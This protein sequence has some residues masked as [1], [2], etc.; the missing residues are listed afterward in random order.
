MNKGIP[1]LFCAIFSLLLFFLAP[2]QPDGW[3]QII[4]VALFLS[5]S[6]FIVRSDVRKYGILNFN[7]L[8]LFSF[9]LVSYA[10][11]LFL[12]GTTISNREGI[13]AYIDFDVSCKCSALC[14]FAISVYFF[15]YK[16][17][18]KTNLDFS[19]LVKTISGGALYVIYYVIVFFLYNSSITHLQDDGGV[20]VHSGIWYSL[21]LACLPLCLVKNCQK[22]HVD[23]LF[24]YF[25]KNIFILVPASLL[26][27]LYFIIGDRGLIIVSGIII[28]AVYSIMV[29]HIRPV[30]LFVGIIVGSTLMYAVRETRSS[31]SSLSSGNSSRFVQDASG[32]V[33]GASVL[34]VF[35]DLTGIH[36][37]LYIGYDYVDHH[38]L[39]EPAQIVIVP[40]YPF[41]LIP[42]VLSQALFGKTM[43][44]IKPGMV[45]NEYMLY[46]GHGHFGTH[47]VIDVYMRWGV[48]GVLLFFY[49]WGYVVASI[50]RHQRK[51]QLAIVMYVVLIASAVSL[52]RQPLV[53][54]LRTYSYVI[55][56]AWISGLFQRKE[57]SGNLII[58][59][60]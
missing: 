57:S 45:L 16:R 38:G 3:F 55:F 30:L 42:N 51:N 59:K 53:D 1:Y 18:E 10:F 60:R 24:Q 22:Y 28:V 32:A 21:Y 48:I 4:C 13:E 56:L 7:I 9:F 14:T 37:E 12:L 33:S 54:I 41:P 43:D 2:K 36:R 5:Q 26:I 50:S 29:R 40:F 31:E 23:G 47:C 25:F 49:L 19:G 58:V 11:P 39:I 34:S 6:F 8:F 52:P 20:Q 44:Q 17:H 15:T 46:S 27:I 35:S